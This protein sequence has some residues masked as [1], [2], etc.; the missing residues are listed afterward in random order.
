MI[1]RE[2]FVNVM[3]VYLL[4]FVSGSVIYNMSPNKFLIIV[5]IVSLLAWLFFPERTINA[6]FILYV[7]I[8]AGILLT[9]SLYTDG[10]LSF[11]SVI[12][13][14]MK[15]VLAYLILKIV[16]EHF[17]ETYI[18][19]VVFLAV[20]SLFGY[21]SD[22]L[23]LFESLIRHLPRL[24]NNGYEGVFYTYRNMWQIGRN[25]SI[26]FEPG[27]YQGF[28]NAALFMLF[29]AKVQFSTSKQWAYI[30][31]LLI[32]LLTT[33]STTGFL[34]FTLM[35]GLFLMKSRALSASGKAALVGLLLVAITL[36]SVQLRHIIFEKIDKYTSTQDITDNVTGGRRAFDAL[37]D[38]EIIKR[39]AFGVGYSKYRQEF[40]AIGLVTEAAAGFSSNGIT[41]TLAMYGIPF[42]LF[43]FASYYWAFGRLLGGGGIAII[44]FGMLLMFFVGEAYYVLTPICLALIAAAFVYDD[45]FTESESAIR[46]A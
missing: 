7:S 20:I 19:V 2:S 40:S 9:I 33:F 38:L 22:K 34:I 13:S 27:A 36:V 1:V 39:N 18:R 5:F 42:G 11:G 30:L 41:R 3:L 35:F 21:L 43:L 12:N 8:F 14:T 17:T 25:C 44:P 4:L 28:L 15:L 37:V 32:T 16:G 6:K 45:R 31:I 24:G 26:F 29:F 23:Y 46:E 10:S